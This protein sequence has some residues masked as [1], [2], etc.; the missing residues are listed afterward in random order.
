VSRKT[1]SKQPKST[2]SDSAL[3]NL[4]LD[5]FF[6]AAIRDRSLYALLNALGNAC[7]SRAEQRRLRLETQT[8]PTIQPLYQEE[9]EFFEAA[10]AQ[11]LDVQ[12]QLDYECKDRAPSAAHGDLERSRVRYS[13]LADEY[14]K[15]LA[16]KV[17]D[18]SASE[19]ERCDAGVALAEAGRD[20]IWINQRTGQPS[21]AVAKLFA[22]AA[23]ALK[24]PDTPGTER[25]QVTEM[26]REL[27]TR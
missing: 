25:R 20:T 11:I 9:I 15:G 23:E 22:E 10:A 4:D 1:K 27:A 12:A 21:F 5:Q 2:L 13:R 19:E 7:T 6:F 8:H 18:P 3:M 26:I 24:N 17:S 16:A 14:L